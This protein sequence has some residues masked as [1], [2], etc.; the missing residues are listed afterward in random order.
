M[1]PIVYSR[2][3][4]GKE[5]GNIL[6]K[7]EEF[8]NSLDFYKNNSLIVLLTPNEKFLKSDGTRKEASI[9]DLHEIT[10]LYKNIFNK[11]NLNYIALEDFN[12]RELI[13]ENLIEEY[14]FK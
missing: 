5:Y 2:F 8:V 9:E 6:E 1:S 7:Q 10:S 12:K 14:W 13:L 3:Y 4:F 11:Y